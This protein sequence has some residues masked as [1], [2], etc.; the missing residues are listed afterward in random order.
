V[1]AVSFAGA[2]SH[3]VTDGV[4]TTAPLWSMGYRRDGRHFRMNYSVS[5][6]DPDFM[7][8]AGFISQAGV[9]NASLSNSYTWLWPH[10]AMQSLTGE[11][12]VQG[13]WL[14]DS[15]MH[16]GAIQNRYL[17]FNLTGS[18][19]GGWGGGASFFT[20][21]FSYDPS[22]YTNYGVQHTDGSITPFVGGNRLPNHDYVLTGNTPTWRHFDLFAYF[23]A[24]LNDENYFEWA[25]ARLLVASI[26]VDYRPTSHLLVNL[27]YNGTQVYRPS[28]GTR[29]STQIVPVATVQYQLSRAFQLR[30]ISQYA[31]DVQDSL[32]DDGRTNLPLVLRDPVTGVYSRAAA[33]HTGDLQTNFLF[34]YLP[35]PGTVV[36]LGYGTIDQQ[37]DLVG[38][39]RLAPLQSD[40]F[41]KLSYLWRGKA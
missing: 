19:K 9:A 29:V 30:V 3:D 33:F 23:L 20:E 18:L 16:G 38:R 35:N 40:F 36:Y 13:H 5:G 6:I 31:L 11:V 26:N 15:L 7:T 28:D 24:G 14:Y 17:H 10:G 21:T 1:N 8:K 25:S 41:V 12:Q 22:I 2:V 32:R 4:T 37:P 39:P 34:T 27:Q